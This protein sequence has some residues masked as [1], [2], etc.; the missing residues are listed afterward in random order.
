MDYCDGVE[1]LRLSRHFLKLN[2]G[3][4][5]HVRFRFFQ[6]AKQKLWARPLRRVCPKRAPV[7]TPRFISTGQ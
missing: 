5:D 2:D 3:N 6:Q 4:A 7:S 1:G